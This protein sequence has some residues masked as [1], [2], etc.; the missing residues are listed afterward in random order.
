MVLARIIIKNWIPINKS[1]LKCHEV[2][3][4]FLE[5]T[6]SHARSHIHRIL[7]KECILNKRMRL[8]VIQT[9][10][11]P[12]QELS[13][14]HPSWWTSFLFLKVGDNIRKNFSLIISDCETFSELSIIVF[15]D[16]IEIWLI[17]VVSLGQN[18]WCSRLTRL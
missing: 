5:R 17:L 3:V 9:C 7:P 14:L 16:P 1:F 2:F 18:S 8:D 4:P 10:F 6:V 13:N 15:D 11:A 12:G